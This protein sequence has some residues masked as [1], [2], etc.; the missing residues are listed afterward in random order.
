MA[1]TSGPPCRTA[2]LV[3]LDTGMRSAELTHLQ[4]RDIDFRQNV[5]HVREKTWSEN[6]ETQTWRPKTRNQRA[7]PMTPQV[8][9]ELQQLPRRNEWVFLAPASPKYPTGDQAAGKIECRERLGGLPRGPADAHEQSLNSKPKRAISK[10]DRIRY[11]VHEARQRIGLFYLNSVKN[12]ARITCS[13]Q[14][15]RKVPLFY[16]LTPTKK[17]EATTWV[18][19]RLPI[20]AAMPRSRQTTR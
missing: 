11:R 1:H 14:K 5:L 4:W 18:E 8:K 16:H 19:K 12:C 20:A 9:A 10:R 17:E 3:L 2:F 7:I 13:N 6:G 15:N